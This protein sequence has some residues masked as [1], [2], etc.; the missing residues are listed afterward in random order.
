MSSPTL[1]QKAMRQPASGSGNSTL[2]P[3]F[4]R[5]S[6]VGR[7]RMR[8][9]FADAFATEGRA[10]KERLEGLKDRALDALEVAVS[11][12]EEGSTAQKDN[13]KTYKCAK[14]QILPLLLRLEDEGERDAALK[15]IAH[16]LK[17]TIKPLRKALAALDELEQE[18][19][20]QEGS[21]RTEEQAPQP[22]TE[23]YERAMEL[24][25]SSDILE[26]AAEDMQLLGHVGEITT[27]RLALIC[28]LSAHAGRPIQPSTHAQ[29]SAGKNALWDA[30][31]SLLPEEMIVRR[32][33]LTAKALFRTEAD[34]KG[35]VLYLQE[36]AGS[37]DANYSIRV[38]Q[39]DGRLEYEATEKAP[40]GSM[41][42]VV[43]RTEGPTVIVQTT[44]KN[45]LHPEN[46]TRVFPIYIDESEEQT[47]RIV[48][49]ILK[50]AAGHG[51]GG[52]ERE[53]VR[54]RWHDAIRLLES[55]LEVVIPYAER[56]EIPT[57]PI[58]IRRD[59][60]RLIDVVRVIAWLHQ[61]GRG[62]DDAGRI[63]ATE[64][65]F[66]LALRLVSES[67]TRAWRTLA[68]AEETVLAVIDKLPDNLKARGFRRRDLKV[69][70]VSDRRVKEVL[71]SLTD[72]GYLDC[73]GWAGP[74]GFS[75][76]VAP[77][78]EEVSLGISLRPSPD[79]PKNGTFAGY[80]TGRD[81]SAR[82]RPSPDGEEKVNGYREAGASGRNG[83][84]PRETADLQE[85]HAS[86]RT[87]G[88]GEMCIHGFAN[89][90]GCYLCDPK[91]P[92]RLKSEAA[93]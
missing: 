81:A 89:S 75:Y 59:A 65:D 28:A 70:G 1:T 48:E 30:A 24:L 29:S 4:V 93:T 58:R 23:R 83:R 74:Q 21:T 90:R 39:S 43:Y 80:S 71:K 54:E 64:E 61:H 68:P 11:E 9:D 87:G 14:E 85:E 5:Q 6:M 2:K 17:L 20:E 77:E 18:E 44:T 84:R 40:D 63:V 36:V 51:V 22:G 10:A 15:D 86:G 91:H 7:P 34:L 26:K 55:G 32:S 82:Y 88:E 47:G 13:L 45:H 3:C 53:R 79:S 16:K 50:D 38:M 37:E 66:H 33:G 8:K 49:S 78:A 57:S 73:D 92:Y 42:N 46:E 76:T 31:L 72:T 67:L 62:R 27:K 69:K 41:K 60:R 19:T 25:R 12:A 35:A 56:I 52:A